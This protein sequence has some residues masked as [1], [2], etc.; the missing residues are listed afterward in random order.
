[1][2]AASAPGRVWSNK[3]WGIGEGRPGSVFA[4]AP[5]H[6]AQSM[7]GVHLQPAGCAHIGQVRLH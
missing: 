4:C 6:L 2:A 5:E 1:M 7:E 3:S